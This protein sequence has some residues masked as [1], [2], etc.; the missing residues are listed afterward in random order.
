MA[1]RHLNNARMDAGKPERGRYNLFKELEFAGRDPLAVANIVQ[2][3]LQ[4]DQLDDALEIA[5]YVSI[6][7][8]DQK[9][10]NEYVVSW[11]HILDY[12][13]EH[14]RPKTAISLFKEVS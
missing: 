14:G 9:P 5:K 7:G 8:R 3:G 4:A 2:R 6:K 13:M 12:L 11:N 10:G 1:A